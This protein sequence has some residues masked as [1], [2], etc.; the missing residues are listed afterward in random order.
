MRTFFTLMLIFSIAAAVVA[1]IK[2]VPLAFTFTMMLGV[3]A[4][5]FLLSL[6]WR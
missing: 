3:A 4:L 6:I 5:F 2:I 1:L